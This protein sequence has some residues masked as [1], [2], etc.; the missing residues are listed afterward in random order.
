MADSEVKAEIPARP[1]KALEALKKSKAEH[2][3]RVHPTLSLLR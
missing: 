3:L 2:G 1:F